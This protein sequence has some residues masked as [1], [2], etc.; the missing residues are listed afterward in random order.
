MNVYQQLESIKGQLAYV[1]SVLSA[2]NLQAWEAKE[3]AELAKSYEDEIASLK[4]DINTN[5]I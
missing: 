3:Y 4:N 5:I 2:G 1:N